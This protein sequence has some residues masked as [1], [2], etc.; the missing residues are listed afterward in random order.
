MVSTWGVKL[1]YE[2]VVMRNMYLAGICADM[3]IQALIR[4]Y[5]HESRNLEWLYQMAVAALRKL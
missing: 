3:S 5:Y 1:A 4:R 2:S